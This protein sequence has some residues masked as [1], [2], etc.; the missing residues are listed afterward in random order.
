MKIVQYSHKYA[1][2]VAD[3]W[4]NSKK[5]WLG[6]VF[7]TTAENVIEE[8][9]NS[10]RV[11]SWIALEKEKV[12][13]YCNL[14]EYREEA[15]A[16]YIGLLNVR[17]DHHGKKIGKKLLLRAVE[18]TVELGWKRLDLYTWSGNTKAVPLYKKAG[19]FWEDRDDST[20]MMNFIPTVLNEE[21]LHSYFQKFHWYQDCARNLEVKPDGKKENSFE[22]YTYKWKKD[23]ESLE[24]DFCRRGRGLR[25]IKTKDFEITATVE[26]LKLVFECEY[27]IKYQIRNK[28]EKPLKISFSGINDRNIKFHWEKTILVKNDKT[29]TSKFFVG[30]ID[31]EQ[32]IKKTHP[33]VSTKI[34]VDGKSAI[35]QIG[36]MPK[37]PANLTLQK[38][39]GL[40]FTET[41]SE[42]FLDIENNFQETA[43][44]SF[45]LPETD[46]IKFSKQNFNFK[47]RAEEK[48]SILINYFL[49][50]GFIYSPQIKI[51][52]KRK[53]HNELKFQRKLNLSFQTLSDM[54]V[55]NTQQAEMIVNGNFGFYLIKKDYFNRARFI[56]SKFESA[57]MGFDVPHLGKP[58]SSEFNQKKYENVTFE[59][60]GNSLLLC[61]E[62]KSKTY[63]GISFKIFNKLFANGILERWLEFYSEGKIKHKDLFFKDG[64]WLG[65][66]RLTLPYKDRIIET[67][68]ELTG[69]ISNWDSAHLTENWL[70]SSKKDASIGIIWNHENSL[71]FGDWKAYIEYDLKKLSKQK[72][73]KTKPIIFALNTFSNWQQVRKYAQKKHYTHLP[74]TTESL[75]FQINCGN[76]F[77]NSAFPVQIKEFKNQTQAGKIKVSSQNDL[78]KK[79]DLLF[80]EQDQQNFTLEKNV[81]L[82]SKHNI[83]LINFQND[84]TAFSY[85]RRKVIFPTFEQIKQERIEK[86]Q[87][88]VYLLSNKQISIAAAKDFA[89][90]LFS[91]K[92]RDRE[93][94]NNA[95]PKPKI[96]S[97]WNKWFGGIF[98]FPAQMQFK[99]ILNE[100]HQ[101]KFV[102]Q[103]DN[104]GN[105]WQGIAITTKINKFEELKGC[106]LTQYFLLLPS[107]PVLCHM[108]RFQQKLG[109]YLPR[110]H[111]EKNCFVQADKHLQN[112]FFHTLDNEEPTFWAH[113][114]KEMTSISGNKALVFSGKDRPEKMHLFFH[115]DNRCFAMTDIKSL[116][117]WIDETISSQ[118]GKIYWLKPLF[119]I[120]SEN[121]LQAAEL[122]DLLNIRFQND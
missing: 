34:S 16:L 53:D 109:K 45:S 71:R 66:N 35:F 61:A 82:L 106:E 24:I 7:F 22:Y 11:C 74:L 4:R 18:K 103:K 80:S 118:D 51:T 70:F 67:E 58:Y 48:K 28:R 5:G 120:F 119:F 15:N 107:S 31:Q 41:R 59:E 114:G 105:N 89:P 87:K 32:N 81:K 14:Y 110:F 25:R 79:F 98:T 6:E 69:G 96:L 43:E 108:V 37:F 88:E 85:K 104:F 62:F 115:P 49:Q 116:V 10:P 99:S 17:D 60:N 27:E 76:P 84:F 93:W 90:T 86:E 39:Y 20:H 26:N 36:I 40:V 47:L 121:I 55:G 29:I 97:W 12:L 50:K 23:N 117:A 65:R 72:K 54:F 113:A 42:L 63:A 95:F 13:G 21:L 75:S 64:F 44:F 57:G 91:L 52:T 111:L 83:D 9:E 122:K 19:F 68:P 3:M 78:F 77:V 56:D 8:E 2:G 46:E 73:L 38:K 102:E 112:T 94:L 100:D 33:R 92:Y 101:I 30:K 1:A